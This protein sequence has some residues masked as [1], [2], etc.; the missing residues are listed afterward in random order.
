[1]SFMIDKFNEG[2]VHMHGNACG[3]YFESTGEF[4]PLMSDAM[5]ELLEAGL[6]TEDHVRDTAVAREKHTIETLTEYAEHMKNYVPS[7]EEL[8][9]MRA[10]FGEGET[11]VN[12]I[13]GQRIK[14]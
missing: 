6:V 12:V 4:R 2:E 8:F 3:W 11:V 1:M 14:L 5:E 7:D 13:T 9:E 10:A